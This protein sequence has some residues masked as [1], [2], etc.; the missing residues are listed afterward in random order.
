MKVLELT[1]LWFSFAKKKE[2]KLNKEIQPS[3][4]NRDNEEFENI[5]F[6]AKK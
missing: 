5:Y 1:L 4:N 6:F 3:K 2:I